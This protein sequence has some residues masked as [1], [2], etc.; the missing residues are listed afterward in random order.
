MSELPKVRT[1]GI[2]HV[3]LNVDHIDEAVELF[4][5]LFDCEHNIPLYIDS[6]DGI[7]SMNSLR[8]DVI[9]PGSAD[10]FFAKMMKKMGGQG[11]SAVSFYVNDIKE[12]TQR[13]EAAGLKVKSEI[14]YPD[15]ELQTQFY[16]ADS[17]GMALELVY[18]YPDHEE[19][20]AAIKA[21]QAK[22]NAGATQIYGKPG[23]VAASG[24]DHVR[25]R[26][27]NVAEAVALFS[28]LFE[29]EWTTSIDGKS[30]QSS[31]GIHLLATDGGMQ[32]VDAFGIKVSNFNAAIERASH[33]GLQ[34]TPTPE[35]LSC[36]QYACLDPEATYGV[37]LVLVGG[38]Q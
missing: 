15:I 20:I 19:K 11:V 12:A 1:S 23:S 29:C 3:H 36:G 4:T 5:S 32:G 25:L 13:I 10:G 7:N 6:I 27:N 2:D 8:I 30:A 28:R 18:L 14:G 22:E 34:F 33:L 35:Y 37:S 38:E 24:I 17:F 31:L 26:V 21:E 16:A 9:A